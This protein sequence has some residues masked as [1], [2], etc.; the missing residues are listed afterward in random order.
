MAIGNHYVVDGHVATHQ[1]TFLVALWFHAYQTDTGVLSFLYHLSLH[2][3]FNLL[4]KGVVK[5][6]SQQLRLWNEVATLFLVS[7]VFL[8]VLKNT[9]SPLWGIAGLV[10]LAG[11]IMIGIRI[12]KNLRKK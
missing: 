7:I 1:R 10:V 9:I 5:Y 11:A 8:I 12:Y 6:S 2:H 4:K 3:V